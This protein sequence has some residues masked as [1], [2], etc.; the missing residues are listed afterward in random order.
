MHYDFIAIPGDVKSDEA[1]PTY[2]PEAARRAGDKPAP[3]PV[4]ATRPEQT[5]DNTDDTDKNRISGPVFPS[6]P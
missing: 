3:W 4:T 6:Y 2:S 5:T 1:D